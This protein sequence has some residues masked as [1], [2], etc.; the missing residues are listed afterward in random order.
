MSASD[1]QRKIDRFTA[2]RKLAFTMTAEKLQLD[3]AKLR[4]GVIGVVMDF[5]F[6]DSTATTVAYV[7]G[8]ASIYLKD[9]P[10]LIGGYN[11][12]GVPQRARSWAEA[13]AR[14]LP[15]FSKCE[16]PELP[17]AD[18]HVFYVLTTDGIYASPVVPSE[19]VPFTSFRELFHMG[20]DLFRVFRLAAD[21]KYNLKKS[22]AE[23]GVTS[24]SASS[25]AP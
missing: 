23:A 12:D 1:E 5:S 25:S 2:G 24:P 19:A 18:S 10:V 15:H 11:V 4:E 7:T 21:E 13:A 3:P 8:D 6:D 16:Q 20:H 17:P 9:G 22:A 14:V